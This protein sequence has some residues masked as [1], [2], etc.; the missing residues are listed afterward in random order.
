MT[1]GP[2]SMEAAWR[3]VLVSKAGNAQKPKLV[4]FAQPAR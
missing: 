4:A 2:K 3:D 1:S